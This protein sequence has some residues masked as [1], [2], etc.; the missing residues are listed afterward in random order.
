MFNALAG[1]GVSAG[2]LE[3]DCRLNGQ[4][5]RLT[6]VF[7]FDTLPCKG[8]LGALRVR[9]LSVVRGDLQDYAR[10]GGAAAGT[11]A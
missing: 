6:R 10:T 8:G 7:A 1:S 9:I 2:S 11:I 5:A 3:L 4:T